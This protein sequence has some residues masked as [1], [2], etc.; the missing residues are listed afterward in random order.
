MSDGGWRCGTR[1]SIES[2]G[3]RQSIYTE[4]EGVLA[5]MLAEHK[6]T[7]AQLNYTNVRIFPADRVCLSHAAFC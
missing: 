1:V 3:E 6:P 7:P 2:M 4:V 5:G